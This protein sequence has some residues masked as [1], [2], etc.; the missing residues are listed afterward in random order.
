MLSIR[1]LIIASTILTGQLSYGSSE[2]ANLSTMK[3]DVPRSR[4]AD[5]ARSLNYQKSGHDISSQA[6]LEGQRLANIVSNQVHKIYASA[7]ARTESPEEARDEANEMI[8][9]DLENI[10]PELRGEFERIA[11]L[12]LEDAVQGRGS[13]IPVD[14]VKLPEIFLQPLK[15]NNIFLQFKEVSGIDSPFATSADDAEKLSY[16]NLNELLTSMTSPNRGARWMEGAGVEGVSESGRS[17]DGEVSIR[18]KA[19]FLGV[20]VE[21]GPVVKFSREVKSTLRLVA[22]GRY[23]IS[24]RDG[25]FDL[26]E[27]DSNGK[28]ISK[29]RY[30]V[31]YCDLNVNYSSE[32]LV[33][34]G[35]SVVGVGG[36]AGLSRSLKESVSIESRRL[37]I[38]EF[39]SN[40]QATIHQLR[41]ICQRHYINAKVNSRMTVRSLAD[42]QL[43]N[44]LAGVVYSH[45]KTQCGKDSQCVGWFKREKRALVGDRAYPRC[46]TNKSENFR[47]CM[48][49]SAIGQ[50]CPIFEGGKK[51]SAG[52]AFENPCDRGLK[53]VKT[54]DAGLLF[55]QYA[56]GKCMPASRSY[57]RPP[58]I[59]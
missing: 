9:K 12:A 33:S 5:L 25:T 54:K 40:R 38:P 10:D 7:F 21:A 41:D 57:K 20:E 29:T 22:E 19:N 24:K 36:K 44:Q 2:L 18:F 3:V 16:K 1:H 17:F 39:I 52:G 32:T 34:G 15:E 35:F 31:F 26:Y 56:E 30:A 23:P 14:S 48:L 43:R 13:S 6:E 4:L 37:M 59:R 46:V 49:G 28:A 47:F 42:I 58:K 27:R 8:L 55:W 50:A 11:G 53:C 51:V 45:P